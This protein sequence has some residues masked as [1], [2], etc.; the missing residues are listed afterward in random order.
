MSKSIKLF[1]VLT[2]YEVINDYLASVLNLEA[3]P[4]DVELVLPFSRLPTSRPAHFNEKHRGHVVHQWVAGSTDPYKVVFSPKMLSNTKAGYAIKDLYCDHCN[5]AIGQENINRLPYPH[6][7]RMPNWAIELFGIMPTIDEIQAKINELENLRKQNPLHRDKFLACVAT[8]E[9]KVYLRAANGMV[10]DLIADDPELQK[11]TVECA[12]RY[13]NNTDALVTQYHND[14]VEYYKQFQFVMCSESINFFSYVSSKL[15]YVLEAGA[16]PLYWG[17][18]DEDIKVGI[19]NEKALVYFDPSHRMQV[20]SR[21]K[22]ILANPEAFVQE[23]IFKP[24]A[25]EVIFN[26]IYAPIWTQVQKD[27][28]INPYSLRAPD[29]WEKTQAWSKKQLFANRHGTKSLGLK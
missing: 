5:L 14:V 15:A 21:L 28:N 6:Y 25:A 13:R 23:N 20:I 24:G 3:L 12:G 1:N 27:L 19:F 16:I 18:L 22:Q 4:V 8:R 17:D 7:Y 26:T 11:L 9:R 29:Y 10:L 2:G